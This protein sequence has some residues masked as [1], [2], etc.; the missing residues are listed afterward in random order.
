MKGIKLPLTLSMAGHAV[1][2]ALLILK[3]ANFAA[4]LTRHLEGGLIRVKP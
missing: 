4:E 1:C 3:R 2:L